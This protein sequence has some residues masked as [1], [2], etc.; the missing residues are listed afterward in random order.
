MRAMVLERPGELLALR[1]RAVPKP[2]P[3]ELLLAVLACG[4]CRT[5]LHL[6]DG[7]LPDPR[8]PVVPGHE[9]VAR[10]VECGQDVLGFAAG[11][12]VAVPWLAG[13]CGG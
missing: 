12:R 10:V 6:V 8:L 13:T 2:G 11:E 5:D 3:G 7:E 1:E 9:I 4:V